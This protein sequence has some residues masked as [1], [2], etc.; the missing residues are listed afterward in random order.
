M[1][2]KHTLLIV[3]CGDVALR[4]IPLLQTRYRIFGLYR[5]ENARK[6]LSKL[7]ATAL[8]GDLDKPD[9]LTQLAGIA[10]SIVYLA[11][12]PSQGARDTRLTHFLSAITK[13]GILPQ[14]MVYIS[15]SG[16]YGDCGGA[17][18]DETQPVNPTSARAIRRVDAEKQVRRWGIRNRINVSI[19]R[20][21]GIYA[22]DRL[23]LARLQAGHP[24]LSNAEDNYTN[25]IHADDLAL[26]IK[27]ALYWA[28]PGRIYHACDNSQQK[29]GDYFDMVA[30]HFNLPRPPRVSFEQAK[31][32]ISPGMLSFMQ[33]S[34]R[35]LNHRI[36]RELYVTLQYPDVLTGIKA[37]AANTAKSE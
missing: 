17:Q 18:I 33:E 10:Q 20:V 27:A 2:L 11:P 8:Y 9:S 37:A 13:R 4:A 25:H 35:L 22:A 32:V 6:Q 12:P 1:T 19:L 16:V 31:E 5:S 21:P 26:I 28:Q 29:M 3:G 24:A 14:R 36:K 30:D 23:P 7:N 15:T 34:R